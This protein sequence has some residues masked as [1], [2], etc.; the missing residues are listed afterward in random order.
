MLLRKYVREDLD[1][2]AQIN[3]FAAVQLQYNQSILP[4]NIV[5]AECDGSVIGVGFLLLHQT[6]ETQKLQITFSTYT[7]NEHQDNIEADGLLMDGLIN[8]FHQIKKEKPDIT[9]RLR[10]CC[11]TDEIDDMQFFIHKGFSIHSA[12]PVLKYDLT[13]EIAHYKIPEAIT[14]QKLTFDETNMKAYLDADS[15]SSREWEY[16]CE[17]DIWFN[18]GDPSFSCYAAICDGKIIGAISIWNISEE[19]AATENIFVIPEFRRKNIARELISTAL[20]ELKNSNLK[21][22]TLSVN[23]ANLPAM[24]LYLSSGYSLYY[25][26]IEMLCE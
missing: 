17:A 20:E 16:E 11:E 23:G 26:L 5:C 19:R 18:T 21:I 3:P 22:A 7:D 9:V 6:L 15:L 13:K 24:K 8:R 25:N 4:E 12:I 1:S 10:E 2:I 14:I